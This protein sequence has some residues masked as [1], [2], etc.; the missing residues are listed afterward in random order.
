MFTI[1]WVN[2]D[3]NISTS[4]LVVFVFNLAKLFSFRHQY[5]GNRHLGYLIDIRAL[6]KPLI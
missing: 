6:P 2:L 3:L 1:L 4:I 5:L